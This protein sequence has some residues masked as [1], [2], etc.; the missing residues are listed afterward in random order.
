[1]E[2]LVQQI[3]LQERIILGIDFNGHVDKEARQY[4]RFHGGFGFG[5]LNEKGKI[6]LDFSM[7]YDLKIVNTCFKKRDK[8]L[9]TYKSGVAS[10]Q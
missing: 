8:H 6:I 2:G 3:P 4:A 9:I 5:K 10:S 1:M 7:V